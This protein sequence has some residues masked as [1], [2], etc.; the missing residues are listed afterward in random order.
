MFSAGAMV[1]VGLITTIALGAIYLVQ[2]REQKMLE[3]NLNVLKRQETKRLAQVEDLAK[4]FPAREKSRQLAR[5]IELLEMQRNGKLAVLEELT[6][7]SLGNREGFS[8]YLEGLGRQ[9]IP[10]LWLTEIVIGNGGASLTLNGSTLEAVQV[11]QYLQRLSAEQAYSGKEFR[12]LSLSRP[13]KEP[14]KLDFHVST[15]VAAVK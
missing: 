15:E 9:H 12:S 10:N 13:D 7:E 11:P 3:E 2:Q 6:G 5:K 1:W 14:L 4:R 8:L